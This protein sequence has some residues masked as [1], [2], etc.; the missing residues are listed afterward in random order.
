MT[1]VDKLIKKGR[2]TRADLENLAKVGRTSLIQ[3]LFKFKLPEINILLI[4]KLAIFIVFI[5]AFIMA[6]RYNHT[7]FYIR[8]QDNFESWLMSVIICGFGTISFECPFFIWPIKSINIPIKIASTLFFIAAFILCTGITVMN[9]LNV[10]FEKYQNILIQQQKTDANDNDNHLLQL[11]KEQEKEYKKEYDTA[12][13]TRDKY[14]Q[15][16]NLYE[17][18]TKEYNDINYLLSVSKKDVKTYEK[19]LQEK[20][21]LIQGIEGKTTYTELQ[22]ITVYEYAFKDKAKNFEFTQIILPSLLF[23]LI[24]NVSLAIIFFLKE[25]KDDKDGKGTLQKTN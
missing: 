20:R 17:K 15:D 6:L 16:L 12:V 22:K 23:E 24:S 11:Y 4:F 18:Q 10:Q 2:I 14:L 21:D 25:K 13:T 9:I 8:N 7:G 5:F 19:L 3:G 1:E